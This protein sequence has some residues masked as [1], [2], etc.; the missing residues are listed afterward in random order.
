LTLESA[1]RIIKSMKGGV[2]ATAYRIHS[3]GEALET[4]LDPR[5]PDGWVGGEVEEAGAAYVQPHGVSA[6]STLED[7]RRYVREYSMAVRPDDVLVELEGSYGGDDRDRY[8]CRIVVS[9]YRVVCSAHDWLRAAQVDLDE[10]ANDLETA[11]DE[12][13][14]SEAE[15]AY[16]TGGNETVRALIEQ[17][18]RGEW[19]L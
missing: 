8:A 9:S 16:Y 6:C 18:I 11:T 7:L 14:D 13:T 12:G 5:R 4:V 2:K 10:L 19:Q 15:W 1:S 17:R 3:A